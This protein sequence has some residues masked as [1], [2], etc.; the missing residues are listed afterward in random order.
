MDISKIATVV[1]VTD[2]PGAVAVWS[3]LL[4]AE[5]AFVDGDR[6][7]QFDVAG[8]RVALSGTDSVTS[9]PALLLRVPDLA[10]ARA[11]AAA[12]GLKTGEVEEGPHEL[13]CLVWTAEGTEIVLHSAKAG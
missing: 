13:R 1:P 8:A 7:A 3:R 12:A 5:P 9:R 6:W 11:E 2:L 10:A 4:G